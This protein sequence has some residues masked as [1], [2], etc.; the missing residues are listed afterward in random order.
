MHVIA[1]N[2]MYRYN[3]VET[4]AEK[5][6]EKEIDHSIAVPAFVQIWHNLLP[7]SACRMRHQLIVDRYMSASCAETYYAPVT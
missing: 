6:K 2:Q 4:L 7:L 1:H 5:K 3:M